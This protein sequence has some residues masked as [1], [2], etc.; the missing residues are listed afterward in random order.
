M[1]LPNSSRDFKVAPCQFEWTDFISWINDA[2][3]VAALETGRS[4]SPV[5]RDPGA[6][7][8]FSHSKPHFF[9][10]PPELPYPSFARLWLLVFHFRR[11]HIDSEIRFSA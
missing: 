10:V 4:A 1:C 5:S 3:A 2:M 7:K 8:R 6:F 9:G 11:S